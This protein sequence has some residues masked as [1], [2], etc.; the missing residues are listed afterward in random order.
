MIVSQN[1]LKECF[2]FKQNPQEL[3]DGL[4]MLGIEIESI[5]DNA[6]TY[7]GFY[8][9]KV[10]LCEPHP[11][12]DSLSV[13]TVFTGDAESIII[14][15]A[16][17][18]AAGQHV[19]IAKQGAIVPQGGFAI[20]KRKIRGIESNGMI[21]SKYELNLGEDDGGIWVLPQETPIGI[22]LAEYL[23]ANDIIFEIGI[24]PNRAD[25]LSHIGL[26]REIAC[27]NNQLNDFTIP[28]E[29]LAL[30]NYN[31]R[32]ASTDIPSISIVSEDIC[33]R[34]MGILIKGI[35]VGD[36]P[37]WLKKRLE[38]IGL[39]PKNSIVDITNYVLMETG[40]PLHAFDADC[41]SGNSIIVKTAES[42]SSFITL[43]GKERV[44]DNSMLMICDAEKPI[45]IAGV[46]GGKNSEISQSTVNV[47]IESA[48][49]KPSSIRKTAKILGISSDAA[50][51]FERGV[52]IN[53]LPHAALR[54]AQMILDIAGGSMYGDMQDIYPITHISKIIHLRLQKA[55][56]II[57]IPL[58][59]NDIIICMHS[60]GC[61][62]MNNNSEEVV[63]ECPSWRIDLSQEI[64][65]IE[66]IARIRN[67]DSIP[68]QTEV[69][70]PAERSIQSALSQPALRNI[71]RKHLVY[72][73]FSEIV[74]YSFLDK[75]SASLFTD[76]PI[77]LANPLGEEFSVMRP[78]IVPAHIKVIS[79]N[80]RNGKKTLALFDIGKIFNRK[81]EK[82]SG[83]ASLEGYDETEQLMISLTGISGKEHWSEQ[84]KSYDFYDIKGIV[85]HLCDSLL[86]DGITIK[87]D[88]P[89]TLPKVILSKNI[90]SIY[91]GKKYIGCA[92]QLEPQYI[93]SFD[94]DIPVYAAIIELSTLYQLKQKKQF[95][96]QINTF[97][98][99]NRDIAFVADMHIPA[100]K[101][102]E[103]AH[104]TGIP[105]L[106]DIQVFD[107]FI[108]KSLGD[109]KKSIGISFIFQA[110]DRTL[111]DQEIQEA[112]N[113]IVM[114]V[115]QQLDCKVRS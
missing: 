104:S 62:I 47:F 51:R 100:E 92:G 68:S 37:D 23:G 107:V 77:L 36:S 91:A 8:T 32:I 29:Q 58:T 96:K 9:G 56:S 73:G 81:S 17:N 41:V 6:S 111:I 52:D 57:G 106:K 84:S 34:Y 60:I 24:T 22:S 44:L 110:S 113:K 19:I 112:I 25:C 12:A 43:D 27:L 64:D 70:F 45:A 7:H 16:P 108:G 20:A 26:S 75:K 72:N 3:S 98:S 10:L 94:C 42:G 18:I 90:V 93:R 114:K 79:H 28:A 54:A 61:K 95:F 40:Q 83:I 101:I 30:E 82:K 35:T 86:L 115:E 63:V 65:L 49:F 2:N 105:F 21:C 13:C 69:H 99:V 76:N 103:I 97:P 67:Y 89:L 78:S 33:N 53:M 39:R 1:W 31:K 50:Y 80:I 74:T 85:E 87:T 102:I 38:S 5:L 4:M 11:N 109:Q 14:C 55:I 46:M 15:G 88:I 48:Y 59:I 66:E 71:I